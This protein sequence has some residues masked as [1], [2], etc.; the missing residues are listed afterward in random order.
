MTISLRTSLTAATALLFGT[1]PPSWGQG[2]AAP[3]YNDLSRFVAGLP[4]APSS[5]LAALERYP[6]VQ[7]YQTESRSMNEEWRSKRLQ[8]LH[9]WAV[10]EIH[11]SLSRP[12]VIKYPFGGPDFVHAATVFPGVDEYVLVGLEP[13]GS[14]P[15]FLAMSEP[16]LAEYLRQ[17][18]HTLRSIS[19]RSF[20]ITTEMREDFGHQGVDG[21]FAVLLYF[22][23]LTEHDVL[24]GGF[25]KLGPTGETIPSDPG[26]ADGIWLQLRTTKRM[27][28]FPETQSLYYF[29]TDLSN[30]GFKPM[31]P[32]FNFLNQRPGG[33]CYLKAASYLMHTEAFANI[34]NYIVGNTDS[35]LQ[36]ESGIPNDFLGLY[37]N[38]SYFGKYNGPIDMFAEYDQPSL[39]AIYQS[40]VA[41]PLPFGTGYRMRDEDSIQIFGTRKQ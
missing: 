22:A 14:I 40:G 27:A 11:P 25:V 3:T 13:L 6:S 7:R 41:K 19:R 5:S 33:V 35:L 12:K 18:N 4:V 2:V 32:F 16:Q 24:D 15:N 28:G 1:C 9:E 21:V 29:K 20:F 26:S 23:A 8:Q 30:D 17:L 10:K 31:A 36:D 37:F 39:R 38:L 34:R